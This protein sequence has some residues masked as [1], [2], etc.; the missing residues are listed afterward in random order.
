[1]IKVYTPAGVLVI[2]YIL[3]IRIDGFQARRRNNFY[4]TTPTF[5][6]CQA[7]IHRPAATMYTNTTVDTNSRRR[8]MLQQIVTTAATVNLL[9]TLPAASSAADTDTTLLIRI[10]FK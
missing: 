3:I 4:P 2:F 6:V 1:M 10:L 7:G 8:V 9:A 5:E